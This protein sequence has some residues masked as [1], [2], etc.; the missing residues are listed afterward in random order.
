MCGPSTC[1]ETYLYRIP[2]PFG[3]VLGLKWYDFL[4]QRLFFIKFKNWFFDIQIILLWL[5][6]SSYQYGTNN[7]WTSPQV[8]GHKIIIESVKVRK[9]APSKLKANFVTKTQ[10]LIHSEFHTGGVICSPL[11]SQTFVIDNDLEFYVPM[12]F[13]PGFFIYYYLMHHKVTKTMV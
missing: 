7:K 9:I 13:D 12:L 10:V 8:D 3:R 6:F 5:E 1:D 4:N 11:P 2:F